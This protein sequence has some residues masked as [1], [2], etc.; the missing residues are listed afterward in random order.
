MIDGTTGVDHVFMTDAPASHES[1]RYTYSA[2]ASCLA[3]LLAI[4]AIAYFG[5]PPSLD[6][7]TNG[8]AFGLF[9]V[10]VTGLTARFYD[11]AATL[12]ARHGS[13]FKLLFV[14]VFILASFTTMTGASAPTPHICAE[15]Y[16]NDDGEPTSLRHGEYEWCSDTGTNRFVTNDTRDF[17]PGTFVPTETVVAVGGGNATSPGYGTVIIK[18]VDTGT[19]IQ[20]N[21]V[22]LMPKCSKKLMPA[23]TFI[24]KGCTLTFYNYDKVSLRG[25]DKSIIFNGRDIGGLY[26]YHAKTIHAKT[27]SAIPAIR[28]FTAK[29]P[30]G[31][32]FFG[33]PVGKHISAAGDN[34]S[35][36]LLEAHWAYGH[37][38]FDK[39]RK[40]LGLKKGTR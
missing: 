39:L 12:G 31:L 27:N 3:L 13:S 9:L 10:G 4:A 2:Y 32:S 1:S 19:S 22:L 38:H 21:N 18:S 29:Q 23:S 5:P 17:V 35:R 40:L 8:N 16:L 24:Q 34:F 37:L 11:T 14:L 36:H 25:S 6:Y 15:S 28:N 26:Y 7:M 20:C 33:L 30:S